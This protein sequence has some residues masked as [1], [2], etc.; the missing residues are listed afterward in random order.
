MLPATEPRF[1]APT[2]LNDA[3]GEVASERALLLAGGTSVVQWIK[4]GLVTP[5]TIVYLGRVAELSGI[6]RIGLTTLRIGAMVTAREL[7]RSALVQDSLPT[8]AQVAARL[9]NPRVRAVATVGG[10]IALGDPRQ[11]LPPLLL[12]LDAR[13]IVRSRS[14]SRE[15]AL[16]DYY[17]RDQLHSG[18]I[19]TTVLVPTDAQMRVAYLRFVPGSVADHPRVSVAVSLRVNHGGSIEAARIALGA[20]GNAPT[21]AVEAQD[22][23][24]GRAPTDDVAATAGGLAAA[25]APLARDGHG[26]VEYQR[27]MVEEWTRR[28]VV[29]AASDASPSA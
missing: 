11:D 20:I 17:Q 16:T 6:D 18:E 13:L 23:L 28:A 9:G 26:S 21:L 22:A 4:S 15:I 25:T 27:A 12:A 2:S 10:A 3:F 1:V 7:A 14:R 19:V 5:D 24:R 29:T 8:L